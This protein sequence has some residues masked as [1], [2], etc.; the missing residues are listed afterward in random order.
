MTDLRDNNI[1][2]PVRSA[3]TLNN[4]HTYIRALHVFRASTTAVTIMILCSI[5]ITLTTLMLCLNLMNSPR[6]ATCLVS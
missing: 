6:R 2:T 1:L 5:I 4:I 3:V